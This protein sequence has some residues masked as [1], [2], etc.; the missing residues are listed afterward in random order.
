MCLSARILACPSR[1]PIARD[2]GPA[3]WNAHRQGDEQARFR[4]RPKRRPHQTGNPQTETATPT[5]ASIYEHPSPRWLRAGDSLAQTALGSGNH[6]PLAVMF[7]LRLQAGIPAP[8][9]LLP[10]PRLLGGRQVEERRN[11]TREAIVLGDECGCKRKAARGC[12]F[13]VEISTKL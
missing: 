11:Q 10:S 6:P 1:F 12:D 7:S 2:S 13:Q 5:R 3:G 8:E 9:P 4:A